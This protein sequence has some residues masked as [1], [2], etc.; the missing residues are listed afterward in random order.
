[1]TQRKWPARVAMDLTGSGEISGGRESDA[2]TLGLT[3]GGIGWSSPVHS[4]TFAQLPALSLLARILA[5]R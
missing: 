3:T 1:M 5:A 2:T 4:T